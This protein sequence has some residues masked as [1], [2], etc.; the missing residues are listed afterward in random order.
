MT[1][2][3]DFTLMLGAAAGGDADAQQAVLAAVYEDLRRRATA[4]MKR[5]ALGHTLQPTAV[6]HEAWMRL[7][8]GPAPAPEMESRAHFFNLAAQVMR[9]VLVDHARGRSRAKRPGSRVRVELDESLGLADVRAADVV[10]LDDALETLAAVDARQADI[11][12][13]RFFGGMGVDEV[14]AV[15]G[16]SRRTIEA[17]WT[18]AKAWLRRELTRAG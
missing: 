11:V 12:V 1:T 3:M 8:Q 17:E 15:L 9:R 16:L 5:E 4:M 2:P 13:M 18:M 10:A 7:M 14:A 6:V